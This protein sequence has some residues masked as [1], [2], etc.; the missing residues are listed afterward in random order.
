[1][2]LWVSFQERKVTKQERDKSQE[3]DKN[4]TQDKNKQDTK[5]KKETKIKETKIR[6]SFERLQGRLKITKLVQTAA[7]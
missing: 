5:I 7:N 1:M 4:I 3:G 2:D 6:R